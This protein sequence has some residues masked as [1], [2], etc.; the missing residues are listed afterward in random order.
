MLVER[1]ANFDFLAPNDTFSVTMSRDTHS[2]QKIHNRSKIDS[3]QSYFFEFWSNK[4]NFFIFLKE[5]IYFHNF[6]TRIKRHTFS[7]KIIQIKQKLT[8]LGPFQC[9]KRSGL[10]P[11]LFLLKA[12]SKPILNLTLLLLLKAD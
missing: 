5:T 7:T 6:W 3:D 4:V 12:D 1:G 11:L 9:L 2:G 8:K 10:T